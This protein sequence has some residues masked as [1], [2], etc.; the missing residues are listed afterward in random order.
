MQ[1]IGNVLLVLSAL[2][3]T[4]FI[5][6]YHW[7]ALWWRSHDGRHVMAFMAS[8]AM[9][10][11]LAMLRLVVGRPEWFEAVRTLT[12][13]TIPVVLSWRFAI[14]IKAQFSSRRQVQGDSPTG[15]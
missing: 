8:L 7:S 9:V 10:L 1:V 11:D 14:L 3:A 5:V 15:E 13:V 4:A 2:I 12:F 6:V